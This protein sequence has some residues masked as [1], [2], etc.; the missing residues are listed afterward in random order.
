[1]NL[2]IT[3]LQFNIKWEDKAY[4]MKRIEELIVKL[5][6]STDI[7]ILP[8][9][10][11]TGFSMNPQP[12]SESM[13]GNGVNWM[14]TISK[15]NDCV[16]CGSLMIKENGVFRNRF[17]WVDKDKKVQ[18]YDKAHPFCLNN[19]GE[20]F[21]KG[22]E[23]VIIE[24]KGWRILPSICYD[25]RFPVWHRNDLNYDILLNVANWPA[26]RSFSWKQF[27]SARALEN[28]VYSIGINRVG[29]DDFDVPFTGDSRIVSFDGK[30]L[31]EAKENLEELICYALD[32][33][34]LL[35]YREKYPF[36]KDRDDFY[37]KDR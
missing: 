23:R 32:K 35:R 13:D 7:L 18:F 24:Y 33:S 22:K 4:N 29:K 2:T 37:L 27:L 16:V 21:T 9:M 25:L 12:F 14:R 1:M 15:A 28:Q 8:E 6:A 17:L 26:I 19:E 3:G 34:A 10:F 31:V 11:S 30:S 36:L 5:P 20:Y